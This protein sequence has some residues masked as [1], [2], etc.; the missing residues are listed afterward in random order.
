MGCAWELLNMVYVSAV[1]ALEFCSHVF[2]SIYSAFGELPPSGRDKYKPT[3]QLLPVLWLLHKAT[4]RGLFQAGA[5]QGS[6]FTGTGRT[7]SL[8]TYP[9]KGGQPTN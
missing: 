5:Q 9:R 6:F 7:G 3:K 8:Q 2:K 4:G 1:V